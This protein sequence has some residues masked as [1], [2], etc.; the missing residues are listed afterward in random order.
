[1]KEKNINFIAYSKSAYNVFDKPVPTS[2]IIPEWYKKTDKNIGNVFSVGDNGNPSE[3]IKACMPV[4]DI[5][6]AGYF[7]TMPADAYFEK[8]G[9]DYK[10]GWSTDLLSLIESHPVSQYENLNIPNEYHGGVYKFVQPWIIKTPPGYSCLFISP[11]YRNDLPFYILPAIVDTDKHPLPVNFP[12]FLN[13]DF[14]GMIEH[15]TPIVQV[16]PFK[17]ESWK[18]HSTFDSNMSHENEW[19]R[20]KIKISNR[21]KTFFRTVKTWR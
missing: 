13:K 9:E 2:K 11:T 16:I 15:G 6:T 4:F 3:T 14:S 21:Y 17:R 7:I 18:S 20:A 10:I 1:M 12:F 8:I 19:Q 5:M